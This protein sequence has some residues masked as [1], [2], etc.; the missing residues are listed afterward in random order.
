MGLNIISHREM[1]MKTTMRQHF[2]TNRMATNKKLNKHQQEC[3]KI[4]TTY[5]AGV[6]ARDITTV[7]TKQ[8][9]LE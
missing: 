2:T 6:N 4:G 5:I 7:E 9:S 8:Q 3:E 1:Q